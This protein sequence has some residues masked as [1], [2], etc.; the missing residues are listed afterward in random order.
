MTAGPRVLVV[1][2]S[3]ELRLLMVIVLRRAGIAVDDA[4]DGESAL[5]K[6]AAAPPDVLVT[7]RMLPGIDG[8]EVCRRARAL[9]GARTL[10]VSGAPPPAEGAE[11]VD[12][13]MEK[14]FPPA[15]L[16]ARVRALAAEAPRG[17]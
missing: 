6:V 14:P 3:E 2:D 1:D 15:D 16:V 10:L 13:Y 17:A 4:A 7:D 8:L 12:A 11:A 9:C 5:A